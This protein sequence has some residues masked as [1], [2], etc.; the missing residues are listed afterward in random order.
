MVL[1]VY[2]RDTDPVVSPPAHPQLADQLPN[3]VSNPDDPVSGPS[4]ACHCPVTMLA[5]SLVS[6]S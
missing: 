4:L 3:P 6:R 1:P 2:A 5:V